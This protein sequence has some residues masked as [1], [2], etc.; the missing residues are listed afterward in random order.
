MSKRNRAL[1][2]S[3]LIL[4]SSS[5]FAEAQSCLRDRSAPAWLLACGKA[6]PAQ[7]APQ[8]GYYLV[9]LREDVTPKELP[10]SLRLSATDYVPQ[11]AYLEWLSQENL[12]GLNARK[13]LSLTFLSAEHKIDSV[14][15]PAQQNCAWRCLVL[16][17]K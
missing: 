1:G 7:Q 2:V 13:T 17:S 6:A 9:E 8:E 14:L 10:D 15:F 11:N 5:S 12:P 16:V 3:V 4:L